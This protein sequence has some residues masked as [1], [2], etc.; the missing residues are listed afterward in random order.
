MVCHFLFESGLLG[1]IMWRCGFHEAMGTA[2]AIF[3]LAA[4]VSVRA[5]AVG[6][7]NKILAA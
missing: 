5:I 2:S 7:Q 1:T 4:A 6:R 3:H